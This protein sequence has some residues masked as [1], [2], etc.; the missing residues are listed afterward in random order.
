MPNSGTNATL[1]LPHINNAFVE[2]GISTP[3]R[4]QM[5]LAN[6][7]VESGELHTV[8][9]NMNYSSSVL[10]SKFPKYFPTLSTALE[11]GRNP[12]KI[13]NR[14]YANRN[15]NGNEASGDG[16]TYRGAGLI[17]LTFKNT[18]AACALYFKIGN[19]AIGN[20]LRT[21]EGAARSAVWFWTTHLCN[22]NC[23]KGDFSAVCDMV[24]LGHVAAK[25]GTSIGYA[26]RLA[27]FNTAKKVIA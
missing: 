13:A 15:G 17:Q 16:W 14:I 7:A 6:I 4:I 22:V 26:Q 18:Q 25:P 21:P 23:D 10:V 2:F 12:Q 11:Y 20:W 27:F 5:L 1:Y 24:N 8:E 9:E 19:D 3:A